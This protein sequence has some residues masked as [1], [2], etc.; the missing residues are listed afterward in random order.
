MKIK[1]INQAITDFTGD[2]II[3][4]LFQDVKSPGGATR[5]V[6]E[7]MD[8]LI[9]R[10]ITQ[11]ELT[12][13]LGEITL[14]HRCGT[15]KADKVIVVGLGKQNDFD[16][17]RARKAAASAIEKAGEI[18]AGHIGT[19]VHG[20]GLG[21]I[22]PARAAQA[23]VEGTL[24]AL[25]TFNIYKKSENDHQIRTFSIVELEKGKVA[26]FRRGIA[27]GKILAEAQN[28]SRDLINE[29]ANNLTPAKLLMRVKR[30]IRDQRLQGLIKCRHMEKRELERMGMGALLS[31]AQGSSHAAKFIVLRIQTSRKPMVCLIGKTVT[32]DSGGLSIK[33][34]AGMGLMKGDMGGGAVAIGTTIALARAKKKINLMTLIPAV[35]NMP[36]GS[37]YRPGDIVRAM[38]GKTVEIVT[39][40][41]EGRLTLADAIAYGEKAGARLIIDIATLTGGCVVALG[42]SIA[43]IMGNDQDVIKKVIESS[44]MTGE[45]FWQLPLYE[46]YNKL[47]ESDV[48]DLKN[49]GGRNASA[50]TAGLFLQSFVD[51]AKW[52]HIDVAGTEFTDKKTYY[53]P[54]GGTGF[55]VRTLY[56]LLDNL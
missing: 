39:T 41:A 21:A 38:N 27:T 8:G 53:Q 45:E 43:A 48:A 20:G 47:I 18:K 23:V 36:S 16:Y 52:I 42:K 7:K 32:F 44:K 28:I 11:G 35:E 10:L 14:L 19:I 9:S 50:I 25:Y 17:E 51:K 13:K 31:V 54:V 15:L 2:L 37:A 29:P 5:A 30:L 34:S 22:D 40:D 33:P 46:G 4:N 55:G 49:A 3:V 12:G 24:L 26:K 1:L 56:D 6:D